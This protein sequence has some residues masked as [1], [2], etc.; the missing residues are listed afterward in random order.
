MKLLTSK[1]FLNALDK[2]EAKQKSMKASKIQTSTDVCATYKLARPVLA[3]ILP[4]LGFIPGVGPRVV[5]VI[6]ALMAGLDAFCPKV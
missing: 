4:F 1:E 5:N 3:S 2:F 6:N